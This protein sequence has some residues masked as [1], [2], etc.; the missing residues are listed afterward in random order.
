MDFPEWLAAEL[1]SGVTVIPGDH[2]SGLISDHF[3]SFLS[4]TANKDLIRSMDFVIRK[5]SVLQNEPSRSPSFPIVH[6][7]IQYPSNRIP[8]DI[9][10]LN[11]HRRFPRRGR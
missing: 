3:R 10:N 2:T 11:I 8:G 1:V 5:H 4:L 9:V 6:P 7:F